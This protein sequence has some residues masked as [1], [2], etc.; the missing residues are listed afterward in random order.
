MAYMGDDHGGTNYMER[1]VPDEAYTRVLEEHI[2]RYRFAKDFVRGKRVLDI[3]YGEGYEGAAL[4]ESSA[5]SVI[6]VDISADATLH[7]HHGS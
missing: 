7:L 2:G 6:G 5:V 1:M 3:A 4:V